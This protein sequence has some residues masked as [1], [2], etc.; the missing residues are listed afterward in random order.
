MYCCTNI[1]L[2]VLIKIGSQIT[3]RSLYDLQNTFYETVLLIYRLVHL[4]I[5]LQPDPYL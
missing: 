4:C 3:I 5:Q 2:F 1:M